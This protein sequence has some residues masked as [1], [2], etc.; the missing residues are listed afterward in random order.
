[1]VKLMVT[2]I[3]AIMF[4]AGNIWFLKNGANQANSI[5]DFCAIMLM[6]ISMVIVFVALFGM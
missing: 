6:V 4:V 1:M 2:I 5:E 3:S